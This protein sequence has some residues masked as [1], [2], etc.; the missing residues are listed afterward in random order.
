VGAYNTHAQSISN[1]S[2]HFAEIHLAE[3]SSL[4]AQH[5]ITLLSFSLETTFLEVSVVLLGIDL[6]STHVPQRWLVPSQSYSI[7]LQCTRILY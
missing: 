1:L 4:G 6:L 2:D 7:L 5:D 3:V